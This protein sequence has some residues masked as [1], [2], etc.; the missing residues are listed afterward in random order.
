[1]D[2]YIASGELSFQIG[3]RINLKA[4]IDK[5]VAFHL[6]ERKL[7]PKQTLQEQAD[8]TFLLQANVNDTA[9]LRFWLRGYDEQ[10]EVLEP[11]ELREDL[12]Q[13]A[14]ALIRK[15]EHSD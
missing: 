4:I 9:E 14:K 1:L 3:D 11:K 8:G 13:S 7:S 6:G 2:A 5:D 15:Y 12:Y 10:I